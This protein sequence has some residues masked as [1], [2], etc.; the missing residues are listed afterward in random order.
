MNYFDTPFL[1]QLS[2]DQVISEWEKVAANHMGERA[3]GALELL[4][5]VALHPELKDGL[6]NE[7]QVAENS[8]LIKR[9]MRDYFPE[10]LR[11]NE[12][13]AISLPY[14][15]VI[16][17]HTDRSK[18]ILAAAGPGFELNIRDLDTHQSYIL[19]CCII[20]NEYYG[21]HLDFFKPLFCDIPMADGIIRHYRILYN[22]DYMDIVPTERALPISQ[23]EI[24]LLLD[25]YD[26]LEMWRA[27]FPKESWLLRGFSLMTLVDV[28]VENAV[29]IFK[30]KLLVLNAENFHQSVESIFRSI[31]RIPDIGVG[32]TVFNQH[33]GIF[34]AAN[35]GHR[36]K[37]FLLM[38]EEESCSE[39]VLCINSFRSLIREKSFFAISDAE[40]FKASNP[41][42]H[43]ATMLISQNIDSFIL[44]PVIKNNVLLGILELVSPRKKELNSINANKLEVVMPFLTDSIDR[45]IGEVENQVQAFI[46]EKYTTIHSS[47]YWKF[48][49]EAEHLLSKPGSSPDTEPEEIV[50][51]DVY[52]L[53]GQV[54]IKASSEARNSSVQNDLQY[55]LKTLLAV[56][57]EIS[58]ISD[59]ESFLEEELQLNAFLS[60]LLLPLKANTEQLIHNYVVNKVHRYLQQL[61]DEK[62]KPVIEGYFAED[63]KDTGSFHIYR[64]KY[65][66]TIATI[67]E[68]MAAIIDSRQVEAQAI[69]PHYYERFKT[70]GVEHNLYLGASIAPRRQ[71]DIQLLHQLRLWQLRVL[72]EMEKAH[73]HLK[74]KLPYPLEVTTLI[75]IYN[76]EIDIRFRM[77]EKRFDV[78][79]S[80][81][82]RFEIV[83]KRIDKAHVKDSDERI[84]EPG[85]IT[86][87]YAGDNE[88][89]EYIRYIRTLQ[90]E[91]IL[92]A[93]VELFEVE[94][95]QGV[96]GLKA[97]R[98]KIAH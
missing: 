51:P 72:C 42:S 26:D 14:R 32:F 68:K 74:N 47:V 34:K 62:L 71:F 91:G 11:N 69:F 98:A 16:F 2:F 25:N 59:V 4:E 95:L 55:Q 75:L 66:T 58:A 50:F 90:S 89:D 76:T 10:V 93:D 86:L 73:D 41:G 24:D 96:S 1:V 83:K 43:L 81:N 80:Y 87:V 88:E 5:E 13:K 30:E 97:L 52:P 36:M 44:A 54:D 15:K 29:S 64:R 49:E 84:T 77:D 37:S 79:G 40:E 67:N 20:L 94:D 6:T 70:D 33:R 17:N 85:K 19:S 28:T 45:L 22:A 8:G 27:K 60:D 46:Q 35:F 57:K 38:D 65:E 7:Q 21:T 3:A 18:S 23:E 92:E 12:I 53:Y 31:Y 39:D 82:A 78:D 61:R 9:L 48:K 56:L 63:E